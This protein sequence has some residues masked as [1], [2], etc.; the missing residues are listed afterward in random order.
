MEF[1]ILISL[2]NRVSSVSDILKFLS[3]IF[4]SFFLRVTILHLFLCFSPFSL[5]SLT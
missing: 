1:L 4:I 3:I 5:L 2:I